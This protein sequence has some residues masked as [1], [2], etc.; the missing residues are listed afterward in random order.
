MSNTSK[1]LGRIGTSG[2]TSTVPNYNPM[3]P[4]KNKLTCRSL[5]SPTNSLSFTFSPT[6]VVR[7]SFV[8]FLCLLRSFS[9]IL[10]TCDYLH[11][12][13]LAKNVGRWFNTARNFRL[14]S[15]ALAFRKTLLLSTR[16]IE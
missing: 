6:H 8:R 10:V 9:S 7:A 4:N 14:E 1:R 3:K 16:Q 5:L 15:S 2:V 11:G 13:E 12:T